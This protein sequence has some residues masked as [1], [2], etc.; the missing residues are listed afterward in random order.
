MSHDRD[1]DA[2]FYQDGALLGVRSI[3]GQGNIDSGLPTAIGQDGT[4]SYR[5]SLEASQD[6]ARI[7]RRALSDSEVSDLYAAG[8]RTFVG[9]SY[10]SAAPNTTGLGAELLALGSV[11]LASDDLELTAVQLPPNQPGVFFMGD[12]QISL[13][14]G[15]GFRCAGGSVSRFNPPLASTLAGAVSLRVEVG[16][17][18]VF[19]VG[20][21]WNFQYWYRDPGGLLS[22][23]NLTDGL[24]LTW[25]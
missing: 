4:L 24:S 14:F 8:S 13:P 17:T 23:F 3:A 9:T 19:Q 20:T 25:Q 12:V 16:A 7:W 21:T 10:C 6:A 11:Q 2:R 5:P 18:A 22:N 15:D 1:G